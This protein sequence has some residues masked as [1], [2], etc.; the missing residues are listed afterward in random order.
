VTLCRTLPRGTQRREPDSGRRSRRS[1]LRAAAPV[2]LAHAHTLRFHVIVDSAPLLIIQV[3][4]Y[5]CVLFQEVVAD[6]A[7]FWRVYAVTDDAYRMFM[8]RL[9]SLVPPHETVSTTVSVSPSEAVP[10]RNDLTFRVLQVVTL[11]ALNILFCSPDAALKA[12]LPAWTT[13]LQVRLTC[14]DMLQFNSTQ[15]PV[16]PSFHH[17]VSRERN[18]L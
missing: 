15:P 4:I 18:M 16:R 7:K 12:Q 8:S 2:L 5:Y 9:L 6:N 11:Y 13:R 17:I 14:F 10:E 1:D 3:A